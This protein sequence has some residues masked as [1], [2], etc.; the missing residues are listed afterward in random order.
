V[1]HRARLPQ[2]RRRPGGRHRRDPEITWEPWDPARGTN[3]PTYQLAKT[4]SGKLDSYIGRWATEIKAYGR[5]VI[6][7]FA[8]EMN[9]TWYPWDEGV[10]GNKAGTYVKAWRHVTD[11]FDAKGATNVT[12]LWS[13]NVPWTGSTP[14]AGLHPGDA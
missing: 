4:A 13:P 14:L 6:L 12:W 3:Q 8:H 5:P 11:V 1:G 10:N 2:R 9:G 7:R